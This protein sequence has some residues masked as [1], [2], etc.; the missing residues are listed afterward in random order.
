MR[1]LLAVSGG[2]DSICMAHMAL[3]GKIMSGHD[4]AIAHCNF[5]L[6]GAESDGDELFVSDFAKAHAATFYRTSFDTKAFAAQAGISIEMAARELR[7]R[8]FAQVCRDEG[9]DAVAVA[10]N[11]N[12]EAETFLLNLL[13][14]TSGRGLRGMAEDSEVLGVRVLRPL[15]GMSRKQIE[16]YAAS[17]ALQYREDSTNSE[18]VYKRNKLRHKVL[19]VFEEINPSYLQTLRRDMQ[20]IAQEN[21]IAQDYFLEAEQ[22]CCKYGEP[23]AEGF[24]DM[25]ISIPELLRLRHWEY[26]LFRL[27][28]SCGMPRDVFSQLTSLLSKPGATVS[29]RRFHTKKAS[30]TI[31][32][33][34]IIVRKR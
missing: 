1:I 19:P 26:V 3:S 15:V 27:L 30:V 8:W 13:R 10:H 20:H 21:D 2:I 22:R 33:K 11:A 18:T 16:E 23:D 7:Y 6:R 25:E 24:R 4:F 12:D 9:F 31:V 32:R 34:L 5:C 17:E 28:E 14:G 29:G